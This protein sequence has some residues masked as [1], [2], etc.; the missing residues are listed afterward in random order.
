MS[1]KL[2]LKKALSYTGIVKASKENPYVAVEDKAI[3]E[4]AVAT[5]YFELMPEENSENEDTDKETNKNKKLDEMNVSELETFAAYNNI[6]LKGITKKADIISKL[7]T[8]L[9]ISKTDE[10]ELGSPTMTQL[11][12]S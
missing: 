12:E 10:V 11:Q 3:A 7:E 5:G 6:S 2:K 1:Y 8:E 4:K 9:S